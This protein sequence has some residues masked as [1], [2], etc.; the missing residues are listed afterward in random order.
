MRE[1]SLNTFYYDKDIPIK[2]KILA[3]TLK[4]RIINDAKIDDKKKNIKR[5]MNKNKGSRLI[6]VGLF[7]LFLMIFIGCLFK[8]AN[9]YKDNQNT[10]KNIEQIEE[11]TAVEEIVDTEEAT[12]LI[13]VPEE[14]ESDYWYYIKFPLIQ[15]DFNELIKKNEDTVAWIQVN[16]TNINYPIVQTDNNDYYLTRSYDKSVNEAGWVFM[17]FRNSSDLNN[18][19]TIIYAHSRLDK[20]MFGSLSKVLK[21]AWYQN[22][23]NHIIKIS[24]PTENSLWQIFSVY[25]IEAENYYI[26]TDFGS[27]NTY[28]EFL[29]TI[30]DRSKYDF[31]VTLNESDSI[32]TLS[33][34]Y[35]DT[36]RTV[37]H[38]KKIKKSLRNS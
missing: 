1:Q 23:D 30:K 8:L 14:P 21:P 31:D 10:D 29:S 20:T 19:N 17:D 34:C 36:E 37:V 18:K 15:V 38:A 7:I 35:S 16:N 24:T 32:I 28:M 26:T 33:T 11:I 25:K 27:E 2:E 22:K 3:R 13:N 4:K 9:W 6:L 12:E 5:R